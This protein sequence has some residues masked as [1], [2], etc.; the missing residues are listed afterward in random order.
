MSIAFRPAIADELS[1]AEKL[2]VRSINDL[3][4]HHAFGAVATSR[5]ADFQAFCLRDDARAAWIAED[6]GQIVGFAL[7]W[8]SDSLWFL[9]E[10]NRPGSRRHLRASQ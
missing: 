7:S 10:L 8:V 2:V 3:T 6:D 1:R 9:A 4:S 5:P